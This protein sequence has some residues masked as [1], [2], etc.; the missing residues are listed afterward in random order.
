M[1]V[2][3]D[4]IYQLQDDLN[5]CENAL[6]AARQQIKDLEEDLQNQRDKY[7]ILEARYDE[8]KGSLDN[9]DGE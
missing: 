1:G 8:V 5:D 4:R 6:S 2:D 3:R 7:A 9:Y